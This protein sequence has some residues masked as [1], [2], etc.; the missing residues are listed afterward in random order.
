MKLGNMRV[1]KRAETATGKY[2]TRET[3]HGF[4]EVL[5]NSRLLSRMMDEDMCYACHGS[6]ELNEGISCEICHGPVLPGVSIEE[7]HEMKYK[8]R[9]MEM[10]AADFCAPCHTQATMA[11][12]EIFTV[13]SE[14]KK[15][16][17]GRKGITC[18]ECHM[19]SRDGQEPYHGFDALV[20][21]NAGLYEDDL[22]L[23]N[24]SYDFPR[25][26]LMIE[27]RVTGHAVPAGGPSRFLVLDIVFLDEKGAETYKIIEK[28]GKVFTLRF[29]DIADEHQGDLTK[30]HWTSGYVLSRGINL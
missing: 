22:I 4:K 26:N 7:T 5:N 10:D 21:L 27:N 3:F 13:F 30:T 12:D 25:I 1:L 11:G 28:F 9:R 16:E 2:T 23:K 24:I 18:Q 15:S 19:K 17:A 14:L 29:Y 6:K 20:R 8:P